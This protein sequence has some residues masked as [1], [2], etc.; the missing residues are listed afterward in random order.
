VD[1]VGSE[2]E[3]PP[4]PVVRRTLAAV[5]RLVGAHVGRYPRPGRPET[6]RSDDAHASTGSP[7]DVIDTWVSDPHGRARLGGEDWLDGRPSGRAADGRHRGEHPSDDGLGAWPDYARGAHKDLSD[8]GA[9]GLRRAHSPLRR[10][11]TAAGVILVAAAALLAL[12]SGVEP[13]ERREPAVAAPTDDAGTRWDRGFALPLPPF[14][15]LP[16]HTP[17]PAPRLLPHGTGMLIG[18]LPAQGTR[19]E[20]AAAQ[21]SAELVAGRYCR[22]PRR[23]ITNVEPDP[24]WQWV[25]A[26]VYSRRRSG[27]P[28]VMM[29]QLRWTG[30][31]YVWLGSLPDLASCG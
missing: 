14:D 21:R 26:R 6:V 3:R 1:V 5:R 11:A 31:A 17:I 24:S 8:G 27:D 15:R 4:W 25:T 7:T 23:L 9:A 13:L 12:R 18:E 28:L 16:G 22:E 30:R 20:L 29:F 10:A 2:P 19:P